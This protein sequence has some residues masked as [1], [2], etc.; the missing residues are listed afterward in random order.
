MWDDLLHGGETRI[1]ADKGQVSAGRAAAFAV[2]PVDER[3]NRLIAKV[4]SRIGHP[5]R[6]PKRRF[7]QI[8]TRYRGLARNRVQLFSLF[9]FGNLHLLRGRPM[10]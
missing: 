10:S 6:V 3:F 5:F 8:K 9:A 7:G 2:H 1:R 4:R